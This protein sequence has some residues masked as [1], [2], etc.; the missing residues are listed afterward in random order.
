MPTKVAMPEMGE[1]IT[2][3]TIIQWLIKEGDVVEQY[4]P[5]VEVNT[6]KVDTEVPSPVAGT[7]LKIMVV[8]DDVVEVHN[9]LCWIG[10]PDEEIPEDADDMPA[11]EPVT[12]APPAPTPTP[13]P[14]PAPIATAPA[15][16]APTGS[17]LAGFISPIVARVATE[18][19]V[20]LGRVSGTGNGGRI[21]KDDVLR[22]IQTG[23]ASSAP[24]GQMNGVTRNTF[25]S[26]LVK[27]LSTEHN[28]DL[29]RITGTGQDGR[30]TKNDINRVIDAGGID[31]IALVIGVPVSAS[32]PPI[33]AKVPGPTPGTTVKLDAVRRSIAKHMV[34]S[35]HTSPHVSTFMEAD[36]TNIS[37]HR[38]ANKVAFA[39]DG[40]K[41]T[42]TVYFVSA[43]VTALKLYPMVNS[44]WTDDG[45]IVQKDINV[46]MATSL[47]ADGL[48]VPVIKNADSLSLLGIARSVNDLAKRAREKQLKPDEVR[49]GTFTITNHGGSGSL[50]ATPIINQPQC[51]IL[52]V[53]MIQKRAVV[54]NDAIAIRPMVYIGLTFDHRILDGAV[55]DY[56]LGTIKQVLEEWV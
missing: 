7:I 42:F 11:A 24:M 8:P 20:D 52:G 46:G 31:P 3:A 27:R 49:G 12:A 6:D 44:S 41:L 25:Y 17:S 10:E 51:G 45:V 21:T 19:R 56:F 2:E 37:A 23:G 40:A 54:I 50:Y 4:D 43:I 32:P 53:G 48:I 33:V 15:A 9:V 55:A 47:G 39:S 1:G 28:L 29:D 35:K 16:T 26:P 30:I 14:A 22:Y 34:H 38:A 5:L 13:T 18:N 36:L